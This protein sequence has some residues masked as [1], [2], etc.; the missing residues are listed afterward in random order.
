MGAGT[1]SGPA[2]YSPS[3][4]FSHPPRFHA[5]SVPGRI[6]W[7]FYRFTPQPAAPGFAFNNRIIHFVLTLAQRRIE[8]I[9]LFGMKQTLDVY[10]GV[11]GGEMVG[12]SRATRELI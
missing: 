11:T 5:R 10:F 8:L 2:L 3:D 4:P 12:E 6:I 7:H 9:L 1:Y